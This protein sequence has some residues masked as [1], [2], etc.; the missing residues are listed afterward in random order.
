MTDIEAMPC[1]CHG[2]LLPPGSPP[3]LPTPKSTDNWTP[4]TLQARF[5]LAE[6]LYLKAHLSQSLVNQL[7]DI[8]AATLV[9]HGNVPP[10]ADHQDLLAQIDAIK[11]GNIPWQSYTAQY[12]WL[13]PATGPVP[14]WMKAEYHLWYRNPRKVIHHLLTNP[15]FASGIDYTPHCDFQDEKRQ[16]RDFMSGDWAWDQCVRRY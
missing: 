13:R 2:N 8:W 16:Y 10:I 6:I 15:D 11:L 3:T 12:Q 14:E 7:L 1:D 5:E 4:F 9:P